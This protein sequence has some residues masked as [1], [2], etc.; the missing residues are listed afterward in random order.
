MRIAIIIP[1]RYGS[2]RFPG[3]PLALIAG[4]SMLSRVYNIARKAVENIDLS[5]VDIDIVI[6]TEDQRIFDHAVS[7]GAKAVHTSDQCATGTDRALDAISKLEDKPDFVINLQGDAPLTPPKII[8]Q[9][10][11]AFIDTPSLQVLTPVTQLDW[12]GLD[13]L[14]QNKEKTPFSG[15]TVI[16]NKYGDAVWFSKN[17]I[18]AIRKE[19]DLRSAGSLS[20]VYRHIGMYG[21]R[22]DV[23]EEF[24]TFDMGHY[25]T[26]EGL[27]QLR[28]LENGYQIRC[29]PVD[30]NGL[31]AMSGVDSKEDVKRTEE[32]ISQY[33][34]ITAL[35]EAC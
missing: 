18:P 27:E 20:P 25:E 19:D 34:E 22:R 14:R 11:Q 7:L 21:Y 17:I 6:A 15:T 10:I 1:A 16:M 28:L 33:G 35:K 31:P 9:M 32:Q 5:N 30:L 8:G 4:E 26:L 3:K 13:L 23:L 12:D 2:T 29:V 24:V